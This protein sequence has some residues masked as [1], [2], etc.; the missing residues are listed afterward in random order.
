MWRNWWN[1]DWQEKPKF[2]EKTCPQHNFVHHKSHM[3]RPPRWEASDYLNISL[4]SV[5][6]ATE[7]PIL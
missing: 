4:R 7:G 2:S 3:T 5:F 1:E 6:L